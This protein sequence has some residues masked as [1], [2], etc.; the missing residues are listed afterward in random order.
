VFPDQMLE[1]L[2]QG[3]GLLMSEA[4]MMALAPKIGRN[5]AHDLITH[6]AAEARRNEWTLKKALLKDSEIRE[7]LSDD[8]I[9][10]SIDPAGY[11]GIAEQT[12]EKI[13]AKAERVLSSKNK[14]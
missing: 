3:G 1:N 12:V 9:E 6:T 10:K 2:K 4:V 5:I 13:V 14:I 7:Y 11:T 8:E